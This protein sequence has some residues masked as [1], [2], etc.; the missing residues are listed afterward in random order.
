MNLA[1]P[2]FGRPRRIDILLGVDVY[3]NIVLQGRRT[4]PPDA[5]VAFE[6]KFG[7]VLAGK[8]G[9]ISF[10]NH[11]VTVN[12]VSTISGDE[13]LSKFWE[14]EETPKNHSMDSY[15]QE[16][17][18]VVRHFK[19]NHRKSKDGRFVVPL[20]CKPGAKALD[21]S[22]TQA[23]RRFLSL[24]QSLRTKNQF[25]DFLDVIEEYF[26]MDDA[27]LVP[28]DDMQKPSHQVSICQCT[29]YTRKAAPQQRFDASAKSSTG[30]SLNDTLMVGPTVHPPLIDVLI[31]FHQHR[32]LSQSM[33]ARCIELL[34]WNPMIVISTDLYR[35]RIQM[36]LSKITE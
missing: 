31:R 1:D 22:R 28:T 21:E 15:L 17:R 27:E 29:L 14:V 30:V 26:E 10:S 36:T 13:L 35:G 18:L 24:E 32:M 6:T 7:W 9:P 25:K 12:H 33:S 2:D 11:C 34:N 19:E 16:E 5:P 20:P 8:T 23:V 4:G 3:A